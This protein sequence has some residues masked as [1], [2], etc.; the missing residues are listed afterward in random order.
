M[1]RTSSVKVLKI[2]HI[3]KFGLLG[4]R[5]INIFFKIYS[6]KRL[7]RII[8]W[9]NICAMFENILVSRANVII[10][11]VISLN[12]LVIAM[13]VTLQVRLEG[14]RYTLITGITFLVLKTA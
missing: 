9:K 10:M 1:A 4:T 8:I 2:S 5:V 12:M 14:I 3:V 11:G 6:S 13:I 7:L